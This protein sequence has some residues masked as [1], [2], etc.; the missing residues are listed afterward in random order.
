MEDTSP[1]LHAQNPQQRFSNRAEDYAKYRPSYPTVAIDQILAGLDQ[2]VAA[3][4][5]A[6]TGISAR[7]LADRG[8]EKVWAIEPNSAMYA[9]AKPHPHVEF[10]QGSAE[11]TGLASQ[12]VDLITCCQAFHWFEPIATLAEFHRILQPAGRLALMWN[13]RD[14]TDPFTQ[15]HNEIIRVAADRQYFDSPSCKDAA[16][17]A[18]SPLFIHYRVH[19]FSFVQPLS[20][21]SLIGLALSS[22]YIPKEGVAHEQMIVDLQTLYERWVG[23]SAGDFVPLAYCTNLYLADAKVD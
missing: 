22:S 16:P 12:S 19:T 17:L 14:Q 10:R 8:A 13:E 4:I 5:G 2:P 3:D 11:Q 21:E 18:E 7:L 9:A 23:R 15:A 1:L 6:G 20:L